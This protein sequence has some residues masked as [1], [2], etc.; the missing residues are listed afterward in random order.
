MPILEE[1]FLI[2][3]PF[4]QGGSRAEKLLNNL[5]LSFTRTFCLFFTMK[6]CFAI[7]LYSIPTFACKKLNNSS[8]LFHIL[9]L[10]GKKV[11]H[12][13]YS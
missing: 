1:H 9:L 2:T 10:K 11:P 4:S 3:S 6:K 8:I 12:A 13:L 5:S 7:L